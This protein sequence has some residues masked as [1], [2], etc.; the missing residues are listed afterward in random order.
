MPPNVT[1]VD[2]GDGTATLS[3]TPAA[4][5]QGNYSITI[6][7][8]NGVTPDATQ[9][10]SLVVNA[11]AA[12]AITSAATTT[13][14]VGAA[15]AFNVA[16]SGSPTPTLTE[17]GALPPNVTFVDNGDG[18]ATLSGTPAAGAQGNYSITITA[19]NGVAP[20]ATQSFSLVVNPVPAAPAITSA[21]T[22]TFTV[23]AAGA[24]NVATS[25]SPTPT[26]TETGALPPNVTFVDN[27]DGTA[28]LGGTPAAGD[29]GQLP[30]TITPATAWR[31]MRRR[32]SADR[33][34]R[35]GGPGNHQRRLLEI[36]RRRLGT[37]TVTATGTPRPP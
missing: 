1:F 11:P 18:T 26:L 21:A 12:P 6:T 9:N 37:F 34:S 24:F 17:T 2:N 29:P 27:G 32:A 5:S 15:G 19:S 28:T 36:R 25:G 20:D 8:S 31:P 35:P 10:F 13:F 16:T 14:T 7:A 33:Q 3:G 23:G 22:T 4:G 30:I